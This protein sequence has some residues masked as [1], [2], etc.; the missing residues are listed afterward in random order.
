M[1]DDYIDAKPDQL[2]RKLRSAIASR[3]GIP[4]LERDVLAFRVAK[5][6]QPSSQNIGEWVWRRRG[7]QYADAWQF[8]GGLGE[9][10]FVHAQQNGRQ[11]TDEV[12]PP[13]ATLLPET[14]SKASIA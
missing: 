7:H 1:G 8:L 12:A 10:S 11:R 2:S 3:L 6:V 5:A 13:H 4:E 9:R 14:L